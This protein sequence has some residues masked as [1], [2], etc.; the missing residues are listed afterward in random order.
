MEEH[1]QEG[2]GLDPPFLATWQQ[3]WWWRIDRSH[4]GLKDVNPA[5]F[6]NFAFCIRGEIALTIMG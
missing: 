2:Q 1:P 4:G 6:S 5:K 3:A